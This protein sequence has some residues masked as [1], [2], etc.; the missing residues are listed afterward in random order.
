MKTEAAGSPVKI[1]SPAQP[2]KIRFSSE[3]CAACAPAQD[4]WLSR[5]DTEIPYFTN[6]WRE[7]ENGGQERWGRGA[8]GRA[9][10][11]NR[12]MKQCHKN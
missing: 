6:N 12:P 7:M 1:L 4:R 8:A 10:Q 11:M 3:D 9:I 5:L 2:E